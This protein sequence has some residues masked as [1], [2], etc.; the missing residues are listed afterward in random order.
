MLRV[1]LT[2]GVA[3]GKTTVARMM[4][5][6]GAHVV[7]ADEIAHQLMRPGEP[8]YYEV[9]RHFGQE[10]V[11]LDGGIDRKKLA[12]VAFGSGRVQELNHIVHPAVIAHQ[13]AWAKDMA[14]KHPDGIAVVEAALMLEAGVGERFDKLV[15]V[16]CG[17]SHKIDRFAR[18][19]NLDLAAAEREVN[20]RM[21]AQFPDEEKARAADCV[22]DNSGTLDELEARVDALMAELRFLAH[23]SAPPGCGG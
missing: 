13:D 9:V 4:E 21:A 20:R 1:G 22:I 11:G 6:R 3:C 7:L 23:K 18:R 15:V 19:H 12:E 14:A 10:I 16:T 8:V 5:K 2:G 17:L